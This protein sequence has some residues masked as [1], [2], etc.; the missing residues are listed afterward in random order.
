MV[1]GALIGAGAG[2]L[3]S[4]M[5][6]QGQS[7][8]NKINRQIARETNAA[9]AAMAERQ[10]EFQ[11]GLFNESVALENTAHQRQVADLRAAGL[12]PMLA[13]G[14]TGA[15]GVA[16]MSGASAA[17]TSGAPMQ[18]E[19]S[20]YASMGSH[21]L[22]AVNTAYSVEK[23]AADT[24]KVQAETIDA[25]NRAGLSGAQ[26]KQAEATLLAMQN[27][28]GVFT[29]AMNERDHAL[30]EYMRA[31]VTKPGVQAAAA[32]MAQQSN[33]EALQRFINMPAANAAM[34]ALQMALR[35]YLTT[36]SKEK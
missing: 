11:R 27:E 28:G 21:V 10:M 31:T 5:A 12:N 20:S 26:L 19:F 17:M 22:G 6:Q 18:N 15:G 25:L 32:A 3:G 16:P 33:E 34:A 30:M 2:L 8:A 35:V 7:G 29:M 14:G 36:Q 13:A 4:H 1:W 9:S 23:V 24:Q